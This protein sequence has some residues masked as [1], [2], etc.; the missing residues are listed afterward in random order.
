MNILLGIYLP[1]LLHTSLFGAELL[2]EDGMSM[3]VYI[4]CTVLA[5]AKG[6]PSPFKGL[7]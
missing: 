1:M 5:M 7:A 2:A 6:R 3:L 4:T